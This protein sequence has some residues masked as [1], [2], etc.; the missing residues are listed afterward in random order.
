MATDPR[1]ENYLSALE[2]VLAPFPVSDRA[3]I[4]TEIKSHVLSA[5][6]RDPQQSIDSILHAMGAP[7]SVANR[8]LLERGLKPTKPPISPAVKWIV[9]GF[10]GTAAMLL[11]FVGTLAWKL[12]PILK[13]D[14]RA[15]RV[16]ILG[17]LIDVNEKEGTVKVGPMHIEGKKGGWTTYAGNRPVRDREITIR[18][19]DGRLEIVEHEGA[20]FAWNCR[21][22]SSTRGA[23]MIETPQAIGLDVHDNHGVRCEIAVPKGVDLSIN[24]KT[25]RWRGKIAYGAAT[26][27][28]ADDSNGSGESGKD[29]E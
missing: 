6:E 7:E 20:D 21:G 15:G 10:M 1:L 13:I 28:N 9:I 25:S 18:I 8:Y 14:E 16:V 22:A 2:R 24:G 5:L 12:S 27:E 26:N 17:G 3:E 4:V 23:A 19:D 29:E 11:L